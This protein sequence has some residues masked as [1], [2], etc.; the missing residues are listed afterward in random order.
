M[1]N[2][3]TRNIARPGIPVLLCLFVMCGILVAGLW[4]FRGPLNGAAWLENENGLRLAGRATLWSTGSFNTAGQQDEESRSLE[5]WLQPSLMKTSSTILS[6]S[7]SDNPFMLTAY[8]YHSVFILN[9][10]VQGGQHRSWT[11]GI[12]GVFRQAKPVFITVASGPQQTA[13]YVDGVLRRKFSQ[14]RIAKDFSG[15]LIIGTSPVADDSWPGQLRG[16]AIYGQELTAAQVLNH[17]ETWTTRGRPEL[18]GDERAIALY[19]FSERSGNVISNAVPGGMDLY[20][21]RRYALVHQTF[22]EPFWKEYQ[23]TWEYWRDILLNIVG[24]VPLGFVFCGYWSSI[25]ADGRAVL[26]TTILGLAVSLT[27]EILQ[28]YLATRD[29]GTMDLITN[30]LGTFL[31][32]KLFDLRAV[33]ALFVKSHP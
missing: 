4:P 19:L 25:R 7:S 27:I 10:G 2:E 1:I 20:I 32:A 21:P 30:T 3:L 18:S 14:V 9:R 31:G 5:L 17:Y 29:S 8:Q 22:L 26:A 15:Q 11:L 23:P 16:I 13:I 24:F 6:F 12:D 28:S 33:R